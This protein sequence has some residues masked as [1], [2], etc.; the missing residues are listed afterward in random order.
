MDERRRIWQ[1]LSLKLCSPFWDEPPL[2]DLLIHSLK[3]TIKIRIDVPSE[4]TALSKISITDEMINQNIKTVYLFDH[5]EESTADS[6][7]I[8]Q[9]LIQLPFFLGCI[10]IIASCMQGSRFVYSFLL[11]RVIMVLNSLPTSK[12]GYSCCP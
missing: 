11:E 4:L 3:T 12:T 6:M 7:H 8:W 2:K 10:M 5:I 9:R 1:L